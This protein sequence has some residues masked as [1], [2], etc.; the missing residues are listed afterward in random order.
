[1]TAGILLPALSALYFNRLDIGFTLSLGAACM[2]VIDSPGP[3]LHKRNA[4][5]IGN[6]LIF[7]V[8]VIT[9]FA[10][11]NPITLGIEIALFCFLFSLLIVYGNRAASVGTAGLLAM[12]FMISKELTYVEI[13]IFSGILLAGGIWYMLFSLLF[14][15]IRPYRAAQQ[16]LGENVADIAQFLR[17]KADFYDASTDID[18]NYHKLVTQ[19]IKVSHNQ[20]NVRE[21]L[22]KTRVN[23]KESTNASRILV[24]T[25]VDLVDM[26]EQIMATH[27]DYGYIRQKFKDTG[28]LES[29]N[30]LLHKMA[31]ELDYVGFMVLS[32]LRYKRLTDLNKDL[33]ALKIKIDEAGNNPDGTSNLVLKKILINLRDLNQKI[34][35]IYDYYNSSSSQLLFEKSN[36]IQIS[37]FVSHQEY[38]PHIF[39]D[40][41]TLG[42]GAFKHALRVALVC[43]VGY[44]VSQIFPLGNHSYWI[45]LTIIVILKPG[46]SLSKERNYQRLTGTIA[47]GIV[48]VIVLYF[49]KD[50]TALFFI[51]LLFM[52]GTYS[53]IR[54]NY[55]IAVMF[56]TPFILIMLKF[57]GITGYNVV[58]ER[59]IDTIIGSSIAFI[60]SYFVFPS[61]EFELI[62][63]SMRDVIYANVNYLVKIG[64]ALAG[65]PV[66]I[67]E[68][69]LA[70]KDV[71]VQSANLSSSFQR[72][73]S[74]P[75]SKQRGIKDIHKF[76]VL[77]HI[78]SSYIA[79]I[80]AG[81]KGKS[82]A[83]ARPDALRSIKKSL[84]V[85][86][87]T[88]VK[89]HG[90]T[91][92]FK[93]DKQLTEDKEAETLEP[94]ADEALLKDQLNF[95]NK[96]SNDIARATDNVVSVN[97]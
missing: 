80:A 62:K 86:N 46:F 76:V 57:V 34:H 92:D 24:L 12:I 33:E 41:L 44:I 91:I 66:D 26:F 64:N 65:K 55:V 10:R 47:G 43:L 25:F 31:D 51:M 72:M 22:F 7:L 2:S 61:W 56:M 83:T 85:L 48:G 1:M 96:I 18:D 90:P 74:E 50:R 36:D 8:A 29:I 13:F 28:V 52:L 23:V 21:M 15:R 87:D 97:N 60:A 35:N 89:L 27:Y 9:G 88:N 77:N 78:L 71:F 79:M 81:L 54:L 16:I 82:M 70:R 30:K 53:F 67:T 6:A 19:Q 58:Q 69:K 3:V 45:L 4:M 37:K 75:K 39:F 38:A 63:E 42:S 40:N 17:V 11:L 59:M 84:A 20:D 95:I 94:S 49:I 32:N 93:V 68:Y 73:T 14:F 5:T